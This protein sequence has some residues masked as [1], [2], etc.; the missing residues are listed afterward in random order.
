MSRDLPND[1]IAFNGFDGEVSVERRRSHREPIVAIG[2]L[3]SPV[4]S[5]RIEQL[6]QVLVTDVSLHGC[7]FRCEQPL[8]IGS[9]YRLDLAVGPCLPGRLSVRLPGDRAVARPGARPADPVRIPVDAALS[10]DDPGPGA[11]FA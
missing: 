5:D 6:A 2:R 4:R 10:G 9:F 8:D 3:L 1:P 7:D 11:D